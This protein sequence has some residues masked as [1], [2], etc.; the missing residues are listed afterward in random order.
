MGV[1]DIR[2]PVKAWKDHKFN[3]TGRK[4]DFDFRRLFYTYTKDIESGSFQDW[5]ELASRE[6]TAG[7]IFPCDLWLAPGGMVHIL[8]TERALDERLRDEFFPDEEQSYALN[9]A[10]IK[11]WEVMYRH[12]V[13][14]SEEEDELRP[15]NGRFQV[16]PGNR[17]FVFYNVHN[18]TRDFQENRLVE[19]FP[20]HSLSVT[21]K[22][23]LKRP[24][25]RFYT[26]TVRAGSEPSEIIDVFGMDEK[27]E[28][29][30]A[31]I[32]ILTGGE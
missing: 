30:Y 18:K 19:I 11:D 26:A 21:L 23:E 27:N 28:M 4:W 29:R 24:F 22:A 1:S 10:I 9:Y 20:D 13:M 25:S 16:T 32:R 31:R 5:I 17:L 14:F 6:E 3:K 12:P 15:G 7:H 8:W 2:E